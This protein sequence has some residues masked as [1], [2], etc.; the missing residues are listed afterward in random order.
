MVLLFVT[1]AWF[2]SSVPIALV[3]ARVIAGPHGDL[4]GMEGS[5]ALYRL[6]DGSVERFALLGPVRK[7]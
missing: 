5:D 6:P 3:L 2:A 1:G 7:H 4:Y